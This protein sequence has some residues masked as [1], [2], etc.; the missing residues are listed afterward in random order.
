MPLS[1]RLE[2]KVAAELS[3]ATDLANAAAPVNL[4]K[5]MVLASG[6][7]ADQADKV[8]ADRRTV[9]AGATD[10]IDLAGALTDPLGAVVSFAKVKA[11]V[12]S[13]RSTT[14]TL[15]VTRPVNGAPIFAAAGDAVAVPPGGVLA[16]AAPGAAGLATVTAGTGDLLDVVNSA[17]ASADY[18][19]VVIGT[20]A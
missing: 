5:S 13:N 18:D 15:T 2:V 10:T 1:T 19:V 4:A 14:Q 16:L 17:G 3:L 7:G 8:F 11:I 12:I 20:S 6:T 9:A